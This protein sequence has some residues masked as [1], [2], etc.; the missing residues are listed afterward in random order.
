[1]L[2]VYFFMKRTYVGTAIRA[3]SQDRQIMA[4]MGVDTRRLY[5]I[6]AALG[7]ALAGLASCLRVLQY[8]IHP[9]AGLSVGPITFL[10]CVVGGLG[11]SACG[12]VAAFVV[13]EV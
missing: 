13:A 4:L 10:I 3:I 7:G 1:M 2:L 11:N 9:F 8:D 12:L 6:T 5:V